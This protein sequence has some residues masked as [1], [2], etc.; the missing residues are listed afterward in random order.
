MTD[1]LFEIVNEI[2][3]D[4]PRTKGTKRAAKHDTE[5]RTSTA[6]FKLPSNRGF[7]TVPLHDE[8]QALLSN[9]AKVYRQ[10]YPVR[11]V[12]TIGIYDVCRDCF[13][14]SA[15]LESTGEPI[16]YEDEST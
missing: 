3:E 6:W 9:E 10:K 7:C 8:Y 5:T 4:E 13:T 15:D 1:P 11:Q 14:A 12:Y 2:P 16:E